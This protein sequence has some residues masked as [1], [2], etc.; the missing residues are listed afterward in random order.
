MI[1]WHTFSITMRGRTFCIRACTSSLTKHVVTIIF[2][3]L[4]SIQRRGQM[5]GARVT[6]TCVKPVIFLTSSYMYTCILYMY[7]T[8]FLTLVV[9][10]ESWEKS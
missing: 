5:C 4:K 3:D 6:H 1:A 2:G 7:T 10:N 9:I 8:E